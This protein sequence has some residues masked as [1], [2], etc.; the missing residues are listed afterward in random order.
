[1]LYLQLRKGP[2]DGPERT[3]RRGDFAGADGRERHNAGRSLRATG[4][5]CNLIAGGKTKSRQ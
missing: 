1:M 5:N 4:T 2:T 3:T